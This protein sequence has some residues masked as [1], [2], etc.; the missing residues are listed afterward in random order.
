MNER[1]VVVGVDGSPGSRAALEYAMAE[2]A[3]RGALLRVVAA[4]TLP[5]FWAGPA[6]SERDRGGGAE[7]DAALR[8]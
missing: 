6:T 4:V 1:D 8:R 7:A 2:A 5:E 3:R